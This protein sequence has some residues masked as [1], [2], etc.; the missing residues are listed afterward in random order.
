MRSLSTLYEEYHTKVFYISL[1]LNGN[2]RAG[3]Q[4]SYFRFK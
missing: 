1:C 3:I 2:E 4:T